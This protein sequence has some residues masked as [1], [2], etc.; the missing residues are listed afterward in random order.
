MSA[1]PSGQSN[2]QTPTPNGGPPQFIRRAQAADPLRPRKKP[3]RRPNLP[4]GASAPMP[5]GPVPVARP[6]HHYPVNGLLQQTGANGIVSTAAVGGWTNPPPPNAIV[7]DFP[8][9]TT[10]R[11]LREGFRYHVAR[12]SSKKDIDPSDQNEFTR[13][14]V[15]HRRDPK[16]SAPGKGMKDE[17]PDAP[18][19]SKEKE[20]LE[21]LKAE[22]EARR[23]ADLAQIAP[24]GSN[25]SA[26]AA[27][28]NQAFRNEKTS[29]VFKHDDNAEDKKASDLRYEEA[30]PWHLEDADNKN[31]WVGSYEAALSDTNAIFIADVGRFMVIPI[32]KWYK[33]IPKGQFKALTIEEAEAKLNKKSK[34]PRWAMRVAENKEKEA[35]LRAPPSKLFTVKGESKSYKNS[36]QSER[37]DMDDLDIDDDLFQDDDEQV[38]VEKNNDDDTKDTEERI[39]RNQLGANIFDMADEAEVERELEK[40]LME[41]ERQKRLEKKTKKALTKR[42]QNLIYEVERD[43][44][45]NPYTESS[46]DESTDED[47]QKENDK[48]KEEESKNKIK[49]ESKLPSGASTKGTN[50]PSGRPKHTDPLKKAKNGLKRSGSPN[51]SES[52]GNESSRK[53]IKKKHNASPES[54]R[55]TPA[56]GSRPMSP[57]PSSSQPPRK[58]SI[59]KLNVNSSKLSEIQNSPPNPSPVH[60]AMS[61][62]EA[63][64][65]EGSDG[66]Q[67]K[68]IKLRVGSPTGSRAGSPAP[69]RAGSVAAAAG[70][71]RAESPAAQGQSTR[72]FFIYYAIFDCSFGQHYS[73]DHDTSFDNIGYLTRNLHNPLK[74]SKVISV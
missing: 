51:L 64:G 70:G 3:A 37:Q 25:A 56:P 68:K 48:K 50:T 23:A 24:T 4:A 66:G 1:S 10:K 63:T 62:G 12:F 58:S 34:E 35:Q 60:G 14:V 61:D 59:I 69:G 18:I 7:Q 67:K 26:H 8:L 28:K 52:S 5:K 17:D 30:L 44:S 36:R 22:K 19:D 9:V 57:A 29:Q 20:K 21:I 39:K 46:E 41:E 33:F 49:S 31:T 27:K 55:N 42:E 43:D 53:K 11:A 45:D 72:F 65:G 16:Q 2:N 54:G 38:T 74:R 6:Q 73:V 40:E 47:K 13:P 32:E 15:L 71:S